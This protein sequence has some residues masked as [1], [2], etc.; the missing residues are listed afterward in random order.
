MTLGTRRSPRQAAVSTEPDSPL[1]NFRGQRG[2][3]EQ[4]VSAARPWTAMGR[5]WVGVGK[6]GHSPRSSRELRLAKIYS[7]IAPQATP[8]AE[9]A[10][11]P[12][13]SAPD[14]SAIAFLALE[15]AAAAVSPRAY[16]PT[17]RC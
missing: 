17:C 6:G 11:V 12:G 7:R 2:Y 16:T 9:A 5:E 15:A 8:S 14:L 4:V 10:R 3:S 1:G 13:G